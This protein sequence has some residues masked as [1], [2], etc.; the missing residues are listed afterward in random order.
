MSCLVG[1]YKKLVSMKHVVSPYYFLSEILVIILKN[2][3][4]GEG[5]LRDRVPIRSDKSGIF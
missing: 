5:K 3:K 4:Q 2:T 1:I